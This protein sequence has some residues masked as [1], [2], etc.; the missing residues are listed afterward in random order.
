MKVLFCVR[1]K[2]KT[3]KAMFHYSLL[4]LQAFKEE[5]KSFSKSSGH[6]SSCG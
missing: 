5:N 2:M 1:P 6:L 3:D 4:I